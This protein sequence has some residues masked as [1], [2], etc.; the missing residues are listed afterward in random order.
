LAYHF[1]T[2][3]KN[4]IMKTIKNVPVTVIT[5]LTLIAIANSNVMAH[6]PGSGHPAVE[7]HVDPSL[8]MCSFDISA[9]LTQNEWKRFTKEG[10]NLLY[11]N[12]LSS[13][14]PLGKMN[15]DLTIELT[16]SAVDETSGAWNNTF[17]HPDSEHYLNEGPRTAVPAMRFKIGLTDK[18]DAGLYVSPT[19]LFG[20]NY[21]F[22]GFEAKYAFINNPETNWAASV[23]ASH[24]MDADIEDFNISITGIDLMASKTFF[25]ILSPYAGV[26]THY[27]HTRE[28]TTEVDLSNES[29]I[30]VRGIVGA[31][32]KWKFVN[33]GY[34]MLVG[35]GFNNRAFKIGVTF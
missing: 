6:G 9:D 2:N 32:I 24:V 8:G 7:L 30:A 1:K 33:L 21:N 16:S 11:L 31:E 23:R 35:D 3:Q 12:P 25:G 13:A 20:A 29:H 17:S 19:T 26:E 34:E 10:G 14:K 27:T 5:C 22:I 18:I 28:V 15:W 4:K